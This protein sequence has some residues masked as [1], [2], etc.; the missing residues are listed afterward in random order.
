MLLAENC[1]ERERL[2]YPGKIPQMTALQK[3]AASRRKIECVLGWDPVQNLL[4]RL[5]VWPFH[6]HATQP[7][8]LPF[9]CPWE[10]TSEER[11]EDTKGTERKTNSYSS[12]R[13]DGPENKWDSKSKGKSGAEEG[14]RQHAAS[15]NFLRLGESY[16]TFAHFSSNSGT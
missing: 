6:I 15:C 4:W 13:M 11:K 10:W 2:E 9:L 16:R 7:F 1:A 5:T 14:R 3:R 12:G 8:R